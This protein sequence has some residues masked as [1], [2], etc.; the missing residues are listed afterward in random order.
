M[1]DPFGAV[2]RRGLAATAIKVATAIT[3]AAVIAG[4]AQASTSPRP[5]LGLAPLHA[6]RGAHPGIF[7]AEGRQVLLRGVSVNS[8]GDYFRADPAEPAVVKLRAVDLDR[9]AAQGFNTIRL[10]LSWSKLEPERG[11]IDTGE[12]D[13]V[14]AL[15]DEA[16]A[17]GLY[18]VLDMHQDAW[19]K[20]VATPPG[21]SCP[22]GTERAI[23]WDGA[24]AWATLND[25]ASTCRSPGVRETAPAVISAFDS[26]YANR[27]GIADELVNVWS[28]LARAFAADPAVAGYDLFNE[29]HF[30]SDASR[31]NQALASLYSRLVERIRAAERAVPN[32]FGHIIFFEPNILWSGLGKAPIVDPGFTADANIVFAPHLYGGS[33]ARGISVADGYKAA[34]EAASRYGTTMWSGEWGWFGNPATDLA[35]VREYARLQDETLTGG[36]WWQWSQACGDPH[37]ISDAGGHVPSATEAFNRYRCPGSLYAGPVKQWADVLSRPYPRA[38]PGRLSS[39]RSDPSSRRLDAAGTGKGTML[40][41]VPDRGKGRPRVSGSGIG[42]TGLERVP[43]GWLV[44]IRTSGA[45]RVAV[46]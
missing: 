32:G 42:R 19:G 29:P 5:D 39:L 3:A 44:A 41:W 8:L 6:T 23:G 9:L 12:I 18:V 11:H 4:C 36:A 35:K 34:M 7:D 45:Y 28:A 10:V 14:R 43:G 38:A 15:V 30:G 26:F 46:R 1:V 37:S 17:R 27:D 24:P 40:V 21:V 2:V 13:R 31:T 20:E 22:P 25:G 33:L 16:R